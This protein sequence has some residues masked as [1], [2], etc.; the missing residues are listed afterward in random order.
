MEV[1]PFGVG[2]DDGPIDE[3]GEDGSTS[4]E[5][6]V[7]MRLGVKPRKLVED[8]AASERA[9]M[10]NPAALRMAA[11]SGKKRKAQETVIDLGVSADVPDPVSEPA[12]LV[13][14][15]L[16][17]FKNNN[18]NK[19]DSPRVAENPIISLTLEQDADTTMLQDFV[20]R[21]KAEKAVSKKQE[22]RIPRKLVATP[23]RGRRRPLAEL[24]KNSPSPKK[25]D[26]TT[27]TASTSE[28]AAA[29]ETQAE[30]EV[31]SSIRRSR[32]HATPAAR[33]QLRSESVGKAIPLRRAMGTGSAMLERSAA[34]QL[35]ALTE[36]NT[37]RN[38]DDAGKAPP[39]G[40]G[41]KA[42]RRKPV[43]KSSRKNVSWDERLVYIQDVEDK[44][45]RPRLESGRRRVASRREVR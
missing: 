42:A 31:A 29:G 8:G 9:E 41:S 18:C 19:S 10:A 28:K 36:A 1:A 17:S 43:K 6:H 38:R 12:S 37:K 2:N 44:E 4:C 23:G 45:I 5:G 22:T 26:A 27:M 35:A 16:N 20:Q 33:P 14:S 25:A 40:R 11:H 15:T 30:R 34:Q 32:R 21:A 7:R 39:A 3:D 24:D 13:A